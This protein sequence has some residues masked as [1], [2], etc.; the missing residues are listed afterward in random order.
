M[1]AEFI[2]KDGKKGFLI[3]ASAQSDVVDVLYFYNLQTETLREISGLPSGGIEWVTCA[4]NREYFNATIYNSPS[5]VKKGR[6]SEIIYEFDL[7]NIANTRILVFAEVGG[8]EIL[9]SEK[10]SGEE[11]ISGISSAEIGFSNANPVATELWVLLY[12]IY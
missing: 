5:S 9:T 10:P 4:K 6:N 3:T 1:D 8:K 2:Q 12:L 7:K 11:L